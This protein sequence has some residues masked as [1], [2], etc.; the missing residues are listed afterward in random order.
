L[1]G[2]PALLF[3]AVAALLGWVVWAI[4][5]YFIGTRLLPEAQTKS[6]LGEM[7]RTTGFSSSPGMLAI[8]GIIPGLWSL[9]MTVTRIWMLAAMVIAV[10]QALDYRSTGRAIGVCLIGW[11]ILIALM[12]LTGPG[13]FSGTAW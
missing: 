3:S 1:G 5:T 4:M 2:A 9:V 6:D 13:P 7:L 11:L 12:L 8:L 10:R